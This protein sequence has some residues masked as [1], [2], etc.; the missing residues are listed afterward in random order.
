MPPPEADVRVKKPSSLAEFIAFSFLSTFVLFM[1]VVMLFL[2]ST[3]YRRW[4]K[5]PETK[6]PVMMYRLG[7]IW[8]VIFVV[9]HL[10]VCFAALDMGNDFTPW[11]DDLRAIFH[12]ALWDDDERVKYLSPRR[13]D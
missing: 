1:P 2:Y 6:A 4:K 3:D 8:S 5:D 7:I 12:G 13:S 11:A 9:F 10:L